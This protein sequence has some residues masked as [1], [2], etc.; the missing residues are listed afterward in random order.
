[1]SLILVSRSI[2]TILASTSDFSQAFPLNHT[3]IDNPIIFIHGY[4]TSN[5]TLGV[6]QID[7]C[8]N[9]KLNWMSKSSLPFGAIN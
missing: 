5:T 1:M 9:W 7:D 6:R 8:S 4:V 2:M 3:K